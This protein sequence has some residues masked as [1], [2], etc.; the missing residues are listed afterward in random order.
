MD[1]RS[2]P[3]VLIG[4]SKESKAY[5]LFDPATNRVCISRDVVFEENVGRNWENNIGKIC[6]I[7]TWTDSVE[8]ENQEENDDA[9]VNKEN[10][11]N[12]PEETAVNSSEENAANSSRNNYTCSRKKTT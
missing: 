10:D 8:Q 4:V 1:D 3:H 11:S 7:L 6:E 12:T 5:R 9:D 2:K